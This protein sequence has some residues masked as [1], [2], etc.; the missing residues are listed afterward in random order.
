EA[1]L[2]AL[3]LPTRLSFEVAAARRAMASDKKKRGKTLRFVIPTAVGAV[4][5]IDDPGESVDAALARVR[6]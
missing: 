2:E 4:E 5:L 6:A 1:A 3:G